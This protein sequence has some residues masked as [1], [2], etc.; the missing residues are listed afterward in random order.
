MYFMFPEVRAYR[1]D[2]GRL[3]VWTREITVKLFNKKVAER[4]LEQM[5]KVGPAST[6]GNEAKSY[7]TTSKQV[8]KLSRFV[9]S[10]GNAAM[11]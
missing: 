4:A 1:V 6:T 7:F 10:L 2:V 8:S 5:P 9:N 11:R 3:A